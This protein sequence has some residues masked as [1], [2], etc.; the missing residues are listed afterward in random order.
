[1]TPNQVL[2]V[3]CDGTE[4]IALAFVRQFVATCDITQH[5]DHAKCKTYTVG[6]M[7][8]FDVYLSRTMKRIVVKRWL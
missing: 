3:D 2:L 1:M 7:A 4:A 8:I 5:I 6:D